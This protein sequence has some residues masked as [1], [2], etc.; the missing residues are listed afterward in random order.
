MELDSMIVDEQQPAEE[1][2][3]AFTIDAEPDGYL[4]ECSYGGNASAY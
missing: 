3:S 4:V 2:H 1:P